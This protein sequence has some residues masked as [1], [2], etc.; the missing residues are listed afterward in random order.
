MGILN[1]TPDSFYDGGRYM[2]EKEIAGRVERFPK[3]ALAG[4][5]VTRRTKDHFVVFDPVQPIGNVR[6]RVVAKP[7]LGAAHGVEELRPGRTRG[8]HD[9]ELRMPPVGRHLSSSGVGVF[10][11]PHGSQELCIPRSHSSHEVWEQQYAYT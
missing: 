6:D 5:S 10:P 4:R 2:H 9:V 11:G 8:A 3:L 7:G 1:H